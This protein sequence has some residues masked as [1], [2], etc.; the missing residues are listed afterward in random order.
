MYIQY[1]VARRTK[2]KHKKTAPQ[3]VESFTQRTPTR[4][5]RYRYAALLNALALLSLLSVSH[6]LLVFQRLAC[7]ALRLQHKHSK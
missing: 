3:A 6:S 7:G 1:E 4:M 2:E 5:V